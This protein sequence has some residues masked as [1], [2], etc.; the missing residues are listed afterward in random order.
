MIVLLPILA[1]MP[2]PPVLKATAS[3]VAIRFGNGDGIAIAVPQGLKRPDF[4]SRQNLAAGCGAMR[5]E[6]VRALPQWCLRLIV[7]VEARAAPRLRTVEGLWR[8]STRTRPGKMTDFIR[9]ERLLPEAEIRA[10][11]RDAPLDLIRF[12]DVAA[13]VP[14]PERPTMEDWLNHFNAGLK[15]AV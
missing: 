7:L 6:E 14:L 4:R 15:E 3:N 10:I 9:A 11:M 1:A 12:Q 2:M 5:P 13:L 8:R